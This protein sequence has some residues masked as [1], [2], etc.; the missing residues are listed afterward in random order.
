MD[1]VE[2]LRNDLRSCGIETQLTD[3]PDEFLMI[4]PDSTDTPVLVANARGLENYLASMEE[5]AV[6]AYGDS[7]DPRRSARGLLLVNLTEMLETRHV[8]RIGIRSDGAWVNES[9]P[10]SFGIP[11]LDQDETYEWKAERGFEA[12]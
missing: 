6:E 3:R 8:R 10:R 7:S 4:I 12:Q 5:T 1:E 9:T 2:E 11:N